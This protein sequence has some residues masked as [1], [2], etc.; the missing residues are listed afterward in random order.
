MKITRSL[1]PLR[2]EFFATLH[3]SETNSA[4]IAYTDTVAD[5]RITASD[6]DDIDCRVGF[7][8]ITYHYLVKPSGQIEIGRDPRTFTSRGNKAFN[9]S[10][11]WIGVIGGRDE[12][13]NRISTITPAQREAVEELMQRIADCLQVPL[14]VNDMVENRTL[15]DQQAEADETEERMEA[16]LD[17]NE[18][19][20]RFG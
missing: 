17:A 18:A 13:A 16:L 12:Q 4:A 19:T 1:A 7:F 14:E 10:E 9:Y 20:A 3:R 15:R 6:L 2:T 8:G 5:E 11:I